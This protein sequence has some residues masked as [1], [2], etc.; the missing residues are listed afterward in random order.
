LYD[1]Y[2]QQVYRLMVRTVG[3]QDAADV[4]QQVFLQLYRKIDQFAGRSRFDTWL[5]RLAV[6]E[7]YQ[8]LRKERRRTFH[9]ITSEPTGDSTTENKRSEDRELLEEALMRLDPQLR[10][11]FVLRE[12]EGLPYREIADVAGIP[13]GTVGSRLN[14]ARCELQ[15]HLGDSGWE[16]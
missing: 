4:T 11:N 1:L 5:Y 14:R 9:S 15:R 16:K 2:R 3:W 8:Y 6:N 13:E 7:A 10:S 12:V